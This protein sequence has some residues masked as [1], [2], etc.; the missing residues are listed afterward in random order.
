MTNKRTLM[1]R[2]ADTVVDDERR[3]LA[4]QRIAAQFK[5]SFE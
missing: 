1:E 5:K 3:K 2:L 4:R